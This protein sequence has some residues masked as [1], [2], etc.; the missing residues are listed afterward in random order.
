MQ[1]EDSL[2]CPC[3]G[4]QLIDS[5]RELDVSSRRSMPK[6]VL[7]D[8]HGRPY[9]W[10]STCLDRIYLSPEGQHLATVPP[11]G[12]VHHHSTRHHH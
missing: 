8:G 11:T 6:K 12:L 10:C 7:V 9:A 3:C 5:D 2:K 4:G 1:S